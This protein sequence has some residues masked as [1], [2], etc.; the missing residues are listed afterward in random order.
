MSE[1]EDLLERGPTWVWAYV[2]TQGME[3]PR[4]FNGDYYETE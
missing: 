4:T 2:E 1:Y 3:I